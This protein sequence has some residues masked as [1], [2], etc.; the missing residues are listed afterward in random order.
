M[1]RQ[2]LLLLFSACLSCAYGNMASP[3]EQGSKMASPFINQHVE[4]LKELIRITPS[5]DLHSAHIHV[6]YEINA[7]KAGIEIPLLFYADRYSS[8]F[9]V[10][11]DGI[12]VTLLSVP[13]KFYEEGESELD[14][15]QYLGYESDGQVVIIEW[16]ENEEERVFLSDL[17][18]FKMNLDSGMHVI[19]VSY[20]CAAWLDQ[21][22]WTTKF[23]LF[24]S[25]SPAKSWKS[26][27]ELQI[28]V[29]NSEAKV[30]WESNLG[31]NFSSNTNL[32]KWQF[33]DLP[34]DKIELYYKEKPNPSAQT[35]INLGPFWLSILL[36]IPL[37]VLHFIFISVY[38]KSNKEKKFSWVQIVGAMT[39]PLL[40]VIIYMSSH[41]I[42]DWSIGEH[43]SRRH[44]Y[45]FMAMALYP[46][47]L[48]IYYLVTWFYDKKLK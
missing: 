17:L 26:F 34:K 36:I 23:S 40:W 20:N 9:S 27:G 19:E 6:R 1:L 8:A 43:A 21:S 2:L 38:R 45:T 15:F 4:I 25:L 7:R 47:I 35:L 33:N 13:E 37:V 28:E 30:N 11:L 48:P 14:A 46:I 12:E 32:L 29:D 41:D 10:E 22:D 44:G 24:Y 3:I 16:P 18:F 31:P 39:L 5:N 42:I